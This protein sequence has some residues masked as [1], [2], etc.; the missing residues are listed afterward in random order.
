MSGHNLG[1]VREAPGSEV[2]EITLGR[3]PLQ[4]ASGHVPG[5]AEQVDADPVLVAQ[6]DLCTPP[7]ELI[8]ESPTF[9]LVR[10]AYYSAQPFP[11]HV[12]QAILVILNLHSEL[13][14]RRWWSA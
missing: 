3:L 14:R 6:R 9:T 7:S 12:I 8:L 1:D 13:L 4:G 5:C 10:S 2:L 11:S